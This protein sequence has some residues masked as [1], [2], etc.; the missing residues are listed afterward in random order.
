MIKPALLL[1][2]FYWCLP[3]VVQ[4]QQPAGILIY[5]KAGPEVYLLLADHA[6]PRSKDRGWGGF[7]GGGL[8]G[9]TAAKT[10]ARETEEETRG[11]FTRAELLSLIESQTPVIDTNGFALFFAEVPFVPAQ[12]VMNHAPGEEK[13]AYLERGPFAWIPFSEVRKHLEKPLNLSRKDMIDKRFL[14]AGSHSDWFWNV[15]IGNMKLAWETGSLPWM[16]K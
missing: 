4:G 1:L 3:A 8:D 11:Y 15:W 13:W 14:P 10:A 5:F 12:R 16:E 6:T 9:E 7:G 2:I